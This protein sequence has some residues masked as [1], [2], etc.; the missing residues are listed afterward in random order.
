M[1]GTPSHS[2]VR[3]NFPKL[4]SNITNDRKEKIRDMKKQEQNQKRLNIHTENRFSVLSADESLSDDDSANEFTA[5]QTIN[6]T[7]KPPPLCITDHSFSIDKLKLLFGSISIM[8]KKTSVA[9]K[10]FTNN[11]IDFNKCSDI[12]SRNNIEYYTHEWKNQKLMK[13]VLYGLPKTD[14][15]LIKQELEQYSLS[16]VK[17]TEIQPKSADENYRLFLISFTKNST[18]LNQLK[19]VKCINNIIVNWKP[20]IP[21][22][23]DNKRVIQCFSCLMYGHGS[24]NCH[25]TR[26]CMKCACNTHSIA[27]CNVS[28]DNYK[29]LNCIRNKFTDINHMANHPECPCKL[30]YINFRKNIGNPTQ[31]R[32]FKIPI[33]TSNLSQFPSLHGN[34]LIP[35]TSKMISNDQPSAWN[36]PLNINDTTNLSQFPSP[37]GNNLILSTPRIISNEQSSL[38][39]TPLN[40]NDTNQSTSNNLYSNEEL[41]KLF[42]DLTKKLNTF[43][44][45]QEQITFLISQ[46]LK[47]VK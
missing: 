1:D 6:K 18:S 12:L 10:V 19:S 13:V 3:R 38:Q 43:T 42:V 23:N 40:M 41:L 4:R 27:D 37:H 36:T 8:Y 31:I 32:R 35:S 44:S 14:L 47:H 2:E 26:S 16:P 5:R 24:A 46:L 9:T 22:T 20:F 30:K 15:S 17:I 25:R 21:R 39:N 34:N 11:V 45:K 28:E 29:C 33:D 7:E